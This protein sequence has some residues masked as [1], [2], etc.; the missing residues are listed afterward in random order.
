MPEAA[1]D[2][3]SQRI[4][5]VVGHHFGLSGSAAG[6]VHQGD[7]IV[8]IR[9]FRFHERSGSLDTFVKVFESFG[10]FRP[11]AYEAFHRRRLRHGCRDMV[12]DDAFAGADYHLDVCGVATVYDV[13]LRQQVGG[14]NHHCTEFV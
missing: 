7:V 13:F 11:D 3:V 1:G 10:N 14:G 2:D 6:E 12:G 4:G 5:E 8:R 9:M